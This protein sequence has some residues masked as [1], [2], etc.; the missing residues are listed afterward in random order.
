MRAYKQGRIAESLQILHKI[1]LTEPGH[2]KAREILGS[3]LLQQQRYDE[4]ENIL[5]AGIAVNPD[6]GSFTHLL[7]RLKIEQ[8]QEEMAIAILEK[9]L[10][11]GGLDAESSALLALLYQRLG[12]HAT[13]ALHYQY[14]LKTQPTQGKWWLGLAISQEA[15]QQWTKASKSYRLATASSGL[16][17]QLKEYAQQ[18]QQIIHQKQTAT[19]SD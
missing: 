5:I 9:P 4:A 2:L 16:S 3:I 8:G 6:Y 15:Q 7:A 10:P 18:R 19:R 12:Q 17:R 11:K 14:A 13:A 1:L